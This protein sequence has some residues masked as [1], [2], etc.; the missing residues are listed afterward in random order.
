MPVWGYKDGEGKLFDEKIPAGWTDCPTKKEIKKE[1]IK[2]KK[3]K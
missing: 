2:V 1:P 3:D